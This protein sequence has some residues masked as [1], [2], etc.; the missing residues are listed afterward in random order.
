MVGL[1]NNLLLLVLFKMLNL[2]S[3][4]YYQFNNMMI[5]FNVIP[6]YPLD[7]YRLINLFLSRIYDDEYC[8]HLLSITSIFF[9]VLLILSL[10]VFKSLSLV[11]IILFLS[12]KQIEYY[13]LHKR[14]NKNKKILLTN[15]FKNN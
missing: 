9:I 11:I 10:I 5:L 4:I 1:V 6:I 15:Y 3:T 8:Y 14:K 12:V 13:R 2:T 7:G